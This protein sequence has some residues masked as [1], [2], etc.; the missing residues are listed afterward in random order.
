MFLGMGLTSSVIHAEGAPAGGTSASPKTLVVLVKTNE[1]DA[2]SHGLFQQIEGTSDIGID[3]GLSA[4]GVD[5]RLVQ[6]G[7]MKDHFHSD[8]AFRDGGSIGDRTD[9]SGERTRQDVEAHDL[10]L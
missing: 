1:L 8:H 9:T 10:V 2:S 4:V 3:E 5:M 6:R 7:Y